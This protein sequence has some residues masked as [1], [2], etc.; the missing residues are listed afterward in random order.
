MYVP[1]L[2]SVRV[3]VSVQVLPGSSEVSVGQGA[4]LDVLPGAQQ[5]FL[6][7]ASPE[8]PRNPPR[9]PL[10][11]APGPQTVLGVSW[12]RGGELLPGVGSVSLRSGC[13][14]AAAGAIWRQRNVLSSLL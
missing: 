1:V 13:K 8:A 6:P 5:P 14:Q 2:R 9:N 12:A 10:S 4:G 7:D 3:C 11:L